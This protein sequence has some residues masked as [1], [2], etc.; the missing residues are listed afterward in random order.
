MITD[1]VQIKR[2]GE[3]KRAENERFRKHLKSHDY[4]ERRMRVV[5]EEIESQI[6]CTQ[7]ANCCKQATVKLHDRDVEK[8]AKYLRIKPA[9]FLRD[10]TMEDEEQGTVLKFEEGKGCIFLD[11]NDCTVYDARPQICVDFPHLVR[12]NGTITFR[13]WQFIDRATYCPIVYNALEEYKDM[14]GFKR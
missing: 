2:L 6:D 3:Q 5:A 12:G 13:M 4:N 8:L 14:T 9:Q 11:G 1:L 7:C 10:Y